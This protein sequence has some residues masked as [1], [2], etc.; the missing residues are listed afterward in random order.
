MLLVRQCQHPRPSV[1]G[2]RRKTGNQA[3]YTKAL[4]ET[5]PWTDRSYTSYRAASGSVRRK[6]F[7]KDRKE[8]EQLCHRWAIEHYDNSVDI[9]VRDE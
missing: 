4:R 2:N 9:I 5:G 8:S 3:P 1:H 7:T 6:R